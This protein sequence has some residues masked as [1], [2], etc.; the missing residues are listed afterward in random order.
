MRVCGRDRGLV[1]DGGD[2]GAAVSLHPSIQAAR[3]Q[4]QAAPT[5]WPRH[6][7]LARYFSSNGVE[8]LP[9]SPDPALH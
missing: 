8:A 1:P 2:L 5:S 3:W 6:H 9:P 7:R 4:I